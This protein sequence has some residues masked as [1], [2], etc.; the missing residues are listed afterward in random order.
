MCEYMIFSLIVI[1]Y[2]FRVCASD[3]SSCNKYRK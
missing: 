1:S 2:I 3:S